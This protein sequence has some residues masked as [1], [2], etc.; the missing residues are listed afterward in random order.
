VRWPR[1]LGR[2]T[3]GFAASIFYAPLR[4]A[5]V[6]GR[7][8]RGIATPSWHSLAPP[9]A[10]TAAA[11][12]WRAGTTSYR[13]QRGVKQSSATW[14]WPVGPATISKQPSLSMSGCAAGPSSPSTRGVVDL[15]ERI[16]RL[17]A[18]QGDFKYEVIPLAQ[19]LTSEELTRREAA[20]VRL[21]ALQSDLDA[22]IADYRRRTGQ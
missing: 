7:S 14:F 22:L 4:R 10:S 1:V 21:R 8:A 6:V 20:L 2:T 16:A 5:W 19:R 3:T 13:W 17:R 18:Y 11:R 12:T 15:E 9:R